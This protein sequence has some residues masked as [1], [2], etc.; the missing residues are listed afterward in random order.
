MFCRYFLWVKG[1][2]EPGTIRC[3]LPVSA[4]DVALDRDDYAEA[5]N[6]L[7]IQSGCCRQWEEMVSIM[8]P[9][10][11]MVASIAEILQCESSAKYLNST[12]SPVDMFFSS[13]A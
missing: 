5:P 12:V 6:Q 2:S 7:F 4:I 8:V 9:A 3:I 13:I 1:K 10:A 11:S